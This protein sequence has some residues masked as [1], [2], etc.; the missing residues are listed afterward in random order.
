MT[1]EGVRHLARAEAGDDLRRVIA[2]A[3]TGLQGASETPVDT[4]GRFSLNLLHDA[5]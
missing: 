1:V 4:L 3:L 2:T 5:G